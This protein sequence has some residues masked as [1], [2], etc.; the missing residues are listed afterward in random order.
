MTIWDLGKREH[1]ETQPIVLD[2]FDK[3]V[4]KI[5]QKTILSVGKDKF[6]STWVERPRNTKTFPAF[7][8]AINIASSNK[9]TRDRIAEGFIGSLLCAG[10]D[11]QHSNLVGLFSG[12]FASAGAHSI[13]SENFEKSLVVHAVRKIVPS[14]WINDRDQFLQPNKRLES[15]FIS[16]CVVWSLFVG[17]NQTSSIANAAYEGKKYTIENEFYP[18]TISE[19][20]KWPIS[21]SDVALGLRNARDRFV[22]SWLQ[23][24]ELS[25]EANELLRA[26]KD[27]Y[28]CFYRDINT[29]RTPKFKIS[30]WDS[31]WWQIRNALADQNKAANE[32]AQA[33]TARKGLQSKL[34]KQI[35]DYGFMP[36]EIDAED[37]S[38]DVIE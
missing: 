19:I 13:T 32:L 30:Q 17:S 27:V 38:A 24:A 22:A 34:L 12:P 3:T 5:G 21:D 9:D 7:K 14:T 20:S 28:K 25:P 1:L 2:I 8:S 10:N 16:D 11:T 31:G 6:L 4:H 18:F 36:L 23:N 26:G 33:V 15:T 29:L 37:I 35:Y